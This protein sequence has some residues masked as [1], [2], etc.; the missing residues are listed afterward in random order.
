MC[1]SFVYDSLFVR[2][3]GDGGEG[4]GGEGGSG[5][6]KMVRGEGGR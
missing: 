1:V 2:G 6:G 5:K 4:D 3:G